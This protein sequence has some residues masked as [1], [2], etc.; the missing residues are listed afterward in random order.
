MKSKQQPTLSVE[1]QLML[2]QNFK[3]AKTLVADAGENRAKA[4]AIRQAA[5]MKYEE[6]L[7]NEAALKAK[8]YADFFEEAKK[9]KAE[10]FAP[11]W[12]P[13]WHEAGLTP[14]E[15]A[16][17]LEMPLPQ[18]EAILKAALEPQPIFQRDDV[19]E[20][21]IAKV[22]YTSAGRGGDVL[23]Y[24]GDKTVRFWWEFAG[25]DALAIIEVPAPDQW[26]ART[27]ISLAQR[28]QAL[29]FVAQRTVRNQAPSGGRY[30]IHNNTI[31]IYGQ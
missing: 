24:W 17:R 9:N 13:K 26:E 2:A 30:V 11:R 15:I 4:A 29:N 14:Q 5:Q 21:Q 7:R 23:L 12:V 20:G 28:D 31:T 18:I 8:W 19:F 25:G 16:T 3:K 10:T 22:D 27:G 1:M 6:T